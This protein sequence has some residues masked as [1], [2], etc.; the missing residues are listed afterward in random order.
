MNSRELA[1]FQNYIFGPK[2]KPVW[3]PAIGA[4]NVT[5]PTIFPTAKSSCR[6]IYAR[7]PLMRQGLM[8]FDVDPNVVSVSAHPFQTQYWSATP[9]G[10]PYKQTHIPDVA[11]LMRDGRVICIDYVPVRIQM[12]TPSHAVKTAQLVAH[13]SEEFGW[14]YVV[15]DER[16]VLAQP[17]ASNAQLL[18]RYM[19]CAA[20]HPN[21]D[22]VRH[23]VMELVFPATISA[24]QK[25]L[26]GFHHDVVE[27]GAEAQAFVFTAVMQL[28]IEGRLT[29][30]FSTPLTNSTT[31]C[32]GDCA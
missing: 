3:T 22:Q 17:M 31:V 11:I 23:V 6:S 1:R 2:H 8:Q 28:I 4:W 7:L 19:P 13:Y 5:I 9:E 16:R 25:T 12:E 14:P 30:D 27:L 32:K 29:F 26:V 20:D 24:I 18:W 15:H 21:L 10:D